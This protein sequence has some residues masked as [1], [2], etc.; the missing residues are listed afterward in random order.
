MINYRAKPKRADFRMHGKRWWIASIHYLEWW[1]DEYTRVV[2]YNAKNFE[3]DEDAYYDYQDDKD[4]K[5]LEFFD[6]VDEVGHRVMYPDDHNF[7]SIGA[8]YA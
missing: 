2:S 7:P 8:L 6:K 1:D 5:W 3:T 4:P